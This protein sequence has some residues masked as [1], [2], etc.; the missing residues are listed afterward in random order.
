MPRCSLCRQSRTVSLSFGTQSVLQCRGS[1][2]RRIGGIASGRTGADC[3][4]L[5]DVA[6]IFLDCLGKLHLGLGYRGSI[7]RLV[8]FGLDQVGGR[9]PGLRRPNR[10]L[11]MLQCQGLGALDFRQNQLGQ[12]SC[13]LRCVS[14]CSN[15]GG[16]C[17]GGRPRRSRDTYASGTTIPLVAF[18]SLLPLLTRIALVPFL[19]DTCRPGIT[20]LAFPAEEA[21][22]R[23]SPAA[24]ASSTVLLPDTVV[25]GIRIIDDLDILCLLYTSPSPRD[26]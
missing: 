3:N 6:R 5:G 17:L 1:V 15:L 25:Q 11:G 14:Q 22:D 18:V 2:G 4:S 21:F 13:G 20:L 19:T 7:V 9:R 12:G 10:R 26:S 16:V 23:A 8:Q 24:P